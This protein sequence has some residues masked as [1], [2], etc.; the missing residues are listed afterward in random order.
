[1]LQKEKREGKKYQNRIYKLFKYIY[2]VKSLYI[3]VG[4]KLYVNILMKILSFFVYKKIENNFGYES[5]I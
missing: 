4:I 3:Y 1:M 5:V 2:E